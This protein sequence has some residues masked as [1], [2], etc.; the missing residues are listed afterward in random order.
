MHVPK[1]HDTFRP[2]SYTEPSM[3]LQTTT[4]SPKWHEFIGWYISALLLLLLI[5][6][7]N[8]WT[9]ERDMRNHFEQELH[10]CVSGWG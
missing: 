5:L 9:R 6:A 7:V 3:P 4:G 10:E 1:S 8:G 2:P